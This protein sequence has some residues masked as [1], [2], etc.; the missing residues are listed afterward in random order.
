MTTGPATAIRVSHL[1]KKYTTGGPPEKYRTFRDA[2]V[3]SVKTP[4][5]RLS[6][7]EP[8]QEFRALKDVSFDMEQGEVVGIIGRN[9]AK[10]PALL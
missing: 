5:K 8:P 6:S 4:F 10:K 2:V 1:Y 9:G 3:R 7:L